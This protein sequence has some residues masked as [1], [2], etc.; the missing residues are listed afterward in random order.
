[1]V[2]ATYQEI[3]TFVTNSLQLGEDV[4]VDIEDV[5]MDMGV[6]LVD[7]DYN[8]HSVR[9]V[10]RDVLKTKGYSHGQINGLVNILVEYYN[11]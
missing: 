11:K 4:G 7:L 10:L 9:T 2:M 1:M 5:I 3:E 8:I 6:T